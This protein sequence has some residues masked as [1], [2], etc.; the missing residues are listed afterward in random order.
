MQESALV[1]TQLRPRI[2]KGKRRVDVEGPMPLEASSARLTLMELYGRSAGQPAKFQLA[3]RSVGDER[4]TRL[5]TARHVSLGKE[6]RCPG[7]EPAFVLER[8]TASKSRS[9]PAHRSA[10]RTAGSAHFQSSGKKIAKRL[11]VK[12]APRIDQTVQRMSSHLVPCRLGGQARG[13]EAVQIQAVPQDQGQPARPPLAR[14]VQGHIRDV[15][16]DHFAVQRRCLPVETAPSAE[17]PTCPP[18]PR[19]SGTTHGCR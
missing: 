15:D 10:R 9:V 16:L 6:Q 1:G 5:R 19:S 18:Q 3:S 12:I 14:V 8:R 7:A 13:P 4:K 2:G 17:T 11:E